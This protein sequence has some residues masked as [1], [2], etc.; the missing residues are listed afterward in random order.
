MILSHYNKDH[1]GSAATLLEGFAVGT[2]LR[3]AHTEESAEYEAIL[4]R[5]AP[6]WAAATL[7]KLS[8][9]EHTLAV[10]FDDG[11]SG[12]NNIAT[13]NASNQTLTGAK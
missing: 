3:P 4:R 7:E 6:C 13:L 10:I 12:G 1:I 5:S 8:V 11:W 2:V 9:G